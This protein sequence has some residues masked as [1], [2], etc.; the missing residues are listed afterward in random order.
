MEEKCNNQCNLCTPVAKCVGMVIEIEMR[1]GMG[2]HSDIKLESHFGHKIDYTRL[3]DSI[4][5][6]F[7]VI[8]PYNKYVSW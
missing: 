3:V 8:I 2:F 1:L 5:A 7:K 6:L 4:Q